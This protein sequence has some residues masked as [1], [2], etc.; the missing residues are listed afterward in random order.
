[1]IRRG[2][3][4]A[5]FFVLAECPLHA[6]PPRGAPG[7]KELAGAWKPYSR[8]TN[9]VKEMAPKDV[10]ESLAVVIDNG[11]VVLMEDGKEAN[12]LVTARLFPDKSPAQIDLIV[13]IKGETVNPDQTSP[14]IYKL[15]G[16]LLTVCF[17]EPGRE[18]ERPTEFATKKG[19]NT[20]LIVL[21]KNK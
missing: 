15:E 11:K 20:I 5:W 6:E 7:L 3:C 14:G 1:M 12:F 8:E 9:G 2:L 4:V 10:V 19:D 17:R 13:T 16:D 21:K 18:V